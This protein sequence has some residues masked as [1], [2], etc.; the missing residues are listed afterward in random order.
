MAFDED[1]LTD[2][3]NLLLESGD[4]FKIIKQDVTVDGQGTVSSVSEGEKRIYAFIKN[5]SKRDRKVHEMGLAVSGN[6]TLYVKPSYTITSGGVSETYE[7]LENDILE[8]RA[9]NR[10]RVIK[11]VS[12]PYSSDTKIYKKCVVQNVGLGGSE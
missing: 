10:W 6:R 2:F 5:I 11:I 1:V 3:D 9:G 12:E 8:D 4:V 7:V